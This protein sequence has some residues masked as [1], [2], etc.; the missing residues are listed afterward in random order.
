[1]LKKLK[2]YEAFVIFILYLIPVLLW[3]VFGFSRMNMASHWTL[4]S[5]GLSLSAFGGL[6]VWLLTKNHTPEP[7]KPLPQPEP[8]REYIPSPLNERL[9]EEKEMLESQIETLKVEYQETQEA[10]A[11]QIFSLTEQVDAKSK[12]LETKQKKI[13]ELE[14]RIDEL[15]YEIKALID[16]N[17]EADRAEPLALSEQDAGRLLRKWLDAASHLHEEPHVAEENLSRLLQGEPS[18]LVF[19]YH[20]R[21]EK[22]IS[23]NG[24]TLTLFGLTPEQF[25]EKFHTFV[26]KDSL[27]WHTAL[28]TISDSR[29]SALNLKN[30]RAVMGQ[31]AAGPLKGN[32]IGI[33]F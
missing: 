32:F 21:L 20:K 6:A 29:W 28:N 5:L 23:S 27:D 11:K 33:G 30:A 26:P 16:F 8:I 19:L 15:E 4:F 1:M 7:Q 14:Q 13:I 3:S 25:A 10:D 9:Q 24:H 22:V 12:E 18:A 17:Q 2:S 31:V